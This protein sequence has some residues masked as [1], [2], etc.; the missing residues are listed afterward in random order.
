MDI[1]TKYTDAIAELRKL[2][3]KPRPCVQLAKRPGNAP[4]NDRCGGAGAVWVPDTLAH[5]R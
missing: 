4:I 3:R 5:G 2:Q 1:W